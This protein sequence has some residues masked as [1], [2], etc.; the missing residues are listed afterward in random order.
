M[1]VLRHGGDALRRHVVYPLD[2]MIAGLAKAEV[3]YPHDCHYSGYG[4]FLCYRALMATLPGLDPARIVREGDLQVR[5]IFVAGDIARSVGAPGRR[6]EVHEPAPT[7]YKSIVKGTSYKTH[8]VDVYKTD[9]VSLPTLTLF[10]TSNS[11]RLIPFFVRHFSRIV[12]VAS[13]R[14]FYDLVESERPDYVFAEMPERYFAM[15]QENADE[16]DRAAPP[17]DTKDAFETRTGHKLPLP[18]D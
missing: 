3:F 18:R 13:T 17:D 1:R 4:S 16:T 6:I 10:R 8:Q 11:S 9:E 15:H 7:P 12:A 14:V 5:T 2:E